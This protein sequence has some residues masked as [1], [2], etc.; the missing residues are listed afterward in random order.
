[1]A[2]SLPSLSRLRLPDPRRLLPAGA[3][4][5]PIGLD[6]GSGEVRMVQ[7]AATGDGPPAVA[8]VARRRFDAEDG[9]DGWEAAMPAVRDLLRGGAFA[10]RRVAAA[11]PRSLARVRTVRLPDPQSTAPAEVARRVAEEARNGFGCDV[12]DGS[13]VTHFLP[14]E[15]LRRGKDREGLL[16]AARHVDLDRFACALHAAGAVVAS[17]ELGPL[18]TYRAVERAGRRARDKLDATVVADVGDRATRVAA[19][20]GAAVGLYKSLAVG[21]AAVRRATADALGLRPD[22]A[23][24]IARGGDPGEADGLVA[25]AVANARRVVVADLARELSLCL[26]YYAVTFRGRPPERVVLCG[27]AADAAVR[28]ALHAAMR[29]VLPVTIELHRPLAGLGGTDSEADNAACSLATGLALRACRA[30][31]PRP[32]GATRDEQAARDREEADGGEPVGL[33]DAPEPARR[34][35]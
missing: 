13:W 11:V 30:A 9:E 25:R 35:A 32:H 6:V 28:D 14:G 20:R 8:A 27:R 33:P 34:A 22:E 12:G 23:D 16:V 7:L 17:L 2:P 4:A 19:G 29:P 5:L 21:G 24:A 10:G 26:R 3:A 18:A 1:M 15:P 31:L